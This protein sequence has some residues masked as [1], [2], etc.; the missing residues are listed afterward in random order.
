MEVRVK[1]P[2]VSLD[3]LSQVIDLKTPSGV[4]L[5]D[6]PDVIDAI[7]QKIIDKIRDRTERGIS[8]TIDDGGRAHF[9]KFKAPYSNKYQDSPEFKAFG[10]SPGNVNLKL[11]GDMLGLM[12][13]EVDGDSIKIVMPDDQVE[14]AYNHQTGDTVPRRPFFGISKGELGQILQEFKDVFREVKREADDVTVQKVLRRVLNV[15]DDE[16]G[17]G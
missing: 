11:T 5:S 13:F 6:Y 9:G 4:E 12:D 7:G 10:K 15:E 3:E 2:K 1:K 8:L 17:E 14:K 16:D